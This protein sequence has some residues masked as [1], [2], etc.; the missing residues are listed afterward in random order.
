VEAAR[1]SIRRCASARQREPRC[2][3]RCDARRACVLGPEHAYPEAA[4]AHHM[5]SALP[6]LVESGNH[7]P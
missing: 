1:F 2:R 7:R 4:E 5:R 3:L 6:A